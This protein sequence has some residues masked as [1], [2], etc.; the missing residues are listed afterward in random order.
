M[1]V[2]ST[3]KI[4]VGPRI[5]SHTRHPTV[6]LDAVSKATYMFDA[7][8]LTGFWEH[9]PFPSRPNAAVLGNT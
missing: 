7:W 8:A 5:S 2:H 3:L 9:C 1:G 6:P 4:L